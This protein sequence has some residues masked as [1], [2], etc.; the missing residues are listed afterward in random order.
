M[1]SASPA[2]TIATAAGW[3]G[4]VIF[5]FW[6]EL[7]AEKST[8]SG[9]PTVWWFRIPATIILGLV[10]LVFALECLMQEMTMRRWA[11]SILVFGVFGLLFLA[12]GIFNPDTLQLS[13]WI[14]I[15]AGTFYLA[16]AGLA[17]M[18]AKDVF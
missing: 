5:L 17:G 12:A 7:F 8:Y 13:R 18:S 3:I 6:Q 11:T 10:V 4:L 1:R 14:L 15:P 2:A 16:A 9:Y